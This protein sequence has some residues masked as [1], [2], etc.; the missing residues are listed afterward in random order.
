MDGF[1]RRA[2]GVAHAPVERTRAPARGAVR[3]A[4]VDHVR[5]QAPYALL[6]MGVAVLVGYFP[7]VVMGASPWISLLAGAA[8]L[9]LVLQ[10]RG[11]RADEPNASEAG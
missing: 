5:T 7:V 9:W 2:S 4:H 10:L 1:R 6:T 3:T 11:K 8:V